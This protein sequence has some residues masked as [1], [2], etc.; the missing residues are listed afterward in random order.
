MDNNRRGFIKAATFAAAST[1]LPTNHLFGASK[2]AKTIRVVVWDERQP[3]Q[4]QAYE[5]FIGNHIAEHFKT[6]TGFTVRSVG[7]DDPEQGLSDNILNNCDVL[8]WWGHIRQGEVKPEIG[9]K[10]VERVLAG[11]TALIALHASH[12][13]TPFMEAMN[14]R[15]RQNAMQAFQASDRK[16]IEFNFIPPP[17]RNTMP[18]YDTR[19]TPYTA[20]RKFPDGKEKV[21]VYLPY[22][23]F[24]A[25]RG[26][27]KPSTIQILKHKHPI[28]KG[29]PQQFQV[30]Q[31]EMYDEPFHV[32]E[33]DEIILEERWATGEWFRSG[34]LWR[35]GKGQVFYFRPGHEIYPIYKEKWPLQIITNA[36]RWMGS[37][38]NGSSND[39]SN[40]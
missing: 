38:L 4:K 6:Q 13:A 35:L 9:R 29:V 20:I 17:K 19:I 25:Y 27:G 31:T 33:P 37:S 12:W 18:K 14:E 1:L 3:A 16:Q 23:C 8:I 15:T 11:T 34:M 26:D 30:S 28:V 21:D 22:C 10:I 5:N 2:R 32:P 39:S 24:P 36:A 40:G 7:L